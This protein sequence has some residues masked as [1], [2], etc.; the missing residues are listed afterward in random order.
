MEKSGTLKLDLTTTCGFS[1]NSTHDIDEKQ[2]YYITAILHCQEV[3]HKSVY[4]ELKWR[5]DGL[6]K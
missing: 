3:V 4:D 6:E 5:M 2:W 1:V